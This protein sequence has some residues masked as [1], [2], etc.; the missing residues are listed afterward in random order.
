MKSDPLTVALRSVA[1]TK[2]LLEALLIASETFE[3]KKAKK[4]LSL[5][6]QKMKELGR[7]QAE[8]EALVQVREP[9]VRVINFR[10]TTKE[11]VTL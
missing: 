2:H 10:A 4:T 7:L 11:A 5:L 8:M 9:N 3:Y 1:E 6:H